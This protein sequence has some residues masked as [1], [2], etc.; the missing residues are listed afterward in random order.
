MAKIILTHEVSGLGSAG[1]VV[2]VKNGYA[3]NFLFPRGF[4]T[5]WSRGAEKQIESIKNARAARDLASL[6]DAQALAAKL[7][8]TTLTVPVKSGAEGRLFGTV[9]ADDVAKAVEASGLGSIDKRRVE[10]TQRI[11]TTG[12]YQAVVRL[13]EE[14]NANVEFEVVPA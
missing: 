6:E 7:T 5:P 3:R 11:K 10:L 2:D 14:V 9:R 4:A 13:H 12:V 8:S 1:D